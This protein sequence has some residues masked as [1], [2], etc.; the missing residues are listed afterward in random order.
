VDGGQRCAQLVGGVGHELAHLLL[1]AVSF[2]EGLGHVVEQGVQGVPDLPDLRVWVGEGLVDALAEVGC[3]GGELLRGHL[4]G[5]RRNLAQRPQL[6]SDQ[7][8]ADKRCQHDEKDGEQD[9]PG[10]QPAEQG[11][12]LAQRPAHDHA[13]AERV[14]LGGD[15]V[16]THRQVDR[17][18]LAV[19]GHLRE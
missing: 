2:V 18:G 13:V 1:A 8:P 6:A 9:R 7:H 10:E 12:V 3:A 5:R 17:V 16:V 4:V 14:G 19:G 15:A 11:L